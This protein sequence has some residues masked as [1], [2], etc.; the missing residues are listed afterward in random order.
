M[1]HGKH[2]A[3]LGGF[4]RPPQ[5]ERQ[6]NTVPYRFL[7]RIHTL[8]YASTLFSIWKCHIFTSA[9]LR[10]CARTSALRIILVYP[11][12][13]SL[14]SESGDA[15]GASLGGRRLHTRAFRRQHNNSHTYV[16]IFR[17]YFSHFRRFVRPPQPERW[18]RPPKL[19][20]LVSG[21]TLDP[22]LEG[23]P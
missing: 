18:G 10:N 17:S 15:S 13:S 20:F 19:Q 1:D 4:V 6:V 22:G 16:G 21:V 14:L 12:S 23:G 3:Q 2:D 5:P 9:F 11:E 8:P 7:V